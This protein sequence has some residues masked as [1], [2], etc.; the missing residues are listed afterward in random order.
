MS[1]AL[2]SCA[3]RCWAGVPLC[4]Q[5]ASLVGEDVPEDWRVW[6]KLAEFVQRTIVDSARLG[7]QQIRALEVALDEIAAEFDGEDALKPV[8]RDVINDSKRRLQEALEH[9]GQFV[10]GD[11]PAFE[12]PTP[13]QVEWATRI[14]DRWLNLC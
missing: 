13:E 2:G 3:P 11:L 14:K 6:D 8:F 1:T 9:L 10:D 12:Q 7:W 4:E 5:L